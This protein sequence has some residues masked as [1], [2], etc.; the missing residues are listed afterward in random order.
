MTSTIGASV[1]GVWGRKSVN[2]DQYCMGGARTGETCGWRVYQYD[3]RYYY[4]NGDG[5][6]AGSVYPVTRGHK[7][8]GTGHGG[9]DSGGA[10]Y[11]VDSAGKAWAK[12]IHSGGVFSG[13][14]TKNPASC[15][16]AN[17]CVEV[18]TEMYWANQVFPG[19]VMT[20]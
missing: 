19:D 13:G 20:E 11:T 12:G 4:F 14:A 17:P 16:S 9:G 8:T 10:V 2:G 5:S 3:I 7:A 1:G 18:F 15:T 6:P